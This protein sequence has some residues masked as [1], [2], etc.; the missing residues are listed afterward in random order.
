MI[1]LADQDVEDLVGTSEA[2]DADAHRCGLNS[3]RMAPCRRGRC[4]LSESAECAAYGPHDCPIFGDR[5]QLR[6]P[7]EKA[8]GSER[9]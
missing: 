6:R 9:S 3:R 5:R 4:R 7:R 1:F 8:E 2:I